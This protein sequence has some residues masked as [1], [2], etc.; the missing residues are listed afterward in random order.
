MYKNCHWNLVFL[1]VAD[2]VTIIAF[3]FEDIIQIGAWVRTVYGKSK[4]YLKFIR[5][6]ESA[7]PRTFY[8]V[9]FCTPVAD[10]QNT[11]GHGCKNL[12]RKIKTCFFSESESL[13]KFSLLFELYYLLFSYP[14]Y[15][16][17]F[18]LI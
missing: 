10:R 17:I 8:S 5:D 4:V 9:V 3:L 6:F 13:L 7:P 11:H 12:S 14:E 1:Q 2:L 18:F 16:E 15:S